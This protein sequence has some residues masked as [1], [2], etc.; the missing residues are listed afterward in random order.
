MYSTLYLA[1]LSRVFF[2]AKTKR[3]ARNLVILLRCLR[4]PMETADKIRGFI[5]SKT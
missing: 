3:I 4:I 2:G 5:I 1:R